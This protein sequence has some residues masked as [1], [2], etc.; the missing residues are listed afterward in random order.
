MLF[1]FVKFPDVH[2]LF[3]LHESERKGKHHANNRSFAAGVTS[4][5][6]S[7]DERFVRHHGRFNQEEK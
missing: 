6:A 1:L 5:N 7:D 4:G 2:K 3:S